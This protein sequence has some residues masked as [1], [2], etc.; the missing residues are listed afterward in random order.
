M[1]RKCIYVGWLFA[2]LRVSGKFCQIGS[3]EGGK[4]TYSFDVKQECYII[5][6]ENNVHI[7]PDPAY[8]P[9]LCVALSVSNLHIC[10]YF[11]F[12]SKAC[13]R[14]LVFNRFFKTRLQLT[15]MTRER[16]TAPTTRLEMDLRN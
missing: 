15:A 2:A 1:F 5:T 10:C 8:L 4:A 6:V 3:F 13:R 11:Y 12:N 9:G 14:I 7:L 16:G